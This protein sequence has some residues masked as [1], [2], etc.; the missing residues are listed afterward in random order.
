MK[1]KIIILF[2]FAAIV[3]ITVSATMKQSI[4]SVENK[5][6]TESGIQFTSISFEEALKLAKK[7][8]K[9]IFL[10]AYA[11]WCGPCKMLKK[12]IFTQKEVGDFYNSNFINMAIDME[13]GEGPKLAQK[14]KVQAYPTLLFINHKGEVVGS[15]LG[16]HQADEI[17]ALGK[18]YLK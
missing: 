4:S 13:Q 17:I 3:I 12:N 18:K 7:E 8:K 1:K 10:D 5:S 16:Y 11:S 6:N 2:C 15:A 9:N 14:Y